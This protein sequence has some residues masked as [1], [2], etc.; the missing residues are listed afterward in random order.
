MKD[1]GDDSKLDENVSIFSCNV[2]SGQK[3]RNMQEFGNIEDDSSKDCRDDVR[4]KN[5]P[6]TPQSNPELV[7]VGEAD[8]VI[9]LYC[10]CDSQE[11][12]CGDGDMAETITEWGQPEENVGARVHGL[13]C[14]HHVGEDDQE[15]YETESNKHMVK[16]IPHFPANIR[17]QG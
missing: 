12:A 16:Y 4:K 11:D 14:Q 5:P 1:L 9:P 17:L 6:V 10:N 2:F 15:V 8:C 13:D 3:I 7:R